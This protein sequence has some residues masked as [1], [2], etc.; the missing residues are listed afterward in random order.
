M[1]HQES[2][3]KFAK[4][5]KSIEVTDFVVDPGNSILTASAGGKAGIPLLDLDGTA[6]KVGSEGNDVTL[7]GTV[8]KLTKTGA[9]ALNATFGVTAF[10]PVCP[11]AWSTW[12]P[13]APPPASRQLRRDRH[14]GIPPP[15]VPASS[16]PVAH[17]HERAPF[18]LPRSRGSSPRS[19]STPST[20]T[21]TRPSKPHLS[22]CPACRAEVADYRRAAA[23]FGRSE[24]PTDAEWDRLAEGLE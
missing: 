2:G 22:D 24:I 23:A 8:A 5:N 13:A 16:R 20:P 10:T 17:A 14:D 21:S 11:S 6:V 3:L 19:P 12:W 18:A 1:I 4:G 9:D 15:V 7:D